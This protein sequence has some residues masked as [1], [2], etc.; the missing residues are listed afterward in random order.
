MIQ[1]TLL[2]ILYIKNRG[3]FLLERNLNCDTD[4]FIFSRTLYFLFH[5][6]YHIILLIICLLEAKLKHVQY[7][8]VYHI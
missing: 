6:F 7:E 3:K 5:V 1:L 8:I 2:K 4:V